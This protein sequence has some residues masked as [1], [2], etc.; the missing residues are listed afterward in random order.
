MNVLPDVDP[1]ERRF[2]VMQKYYGPSKVAPGGLVV[3]DREG[4][5]LYTLEVP[6]P[7]PWDFRPFAEYY[8]QWAEIPGYG[9]GILLNLFFEP[10][11]EGGLYAS[12]GIWFVKHWERYVVRQEVV[13]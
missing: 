3:W 4:G 5:V 12:K 13:P 7:S 9:R 8:P 2:V 1:W 6:W 11:A 10:D